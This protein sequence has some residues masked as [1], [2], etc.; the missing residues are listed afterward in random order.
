MFDIVVVVYEVSLTKASTLTSLQKV[1]AR[2]ACPELRK[3]YV[4]DNSS[5]RQ[6]AE[7]LDERF[8][9]HFAGENLGLAR[10]YNY[11]WPKSMAAGC[12]WLIT[13]DQD[14][15]ITGEYLNILVRNM[16]N[17]IEKLGIIA[18][19]IYDKGQQISPVYSNTLRPLKKALP[20]SGEYDRDIMVINS[21]A[22]VRITALKQIDGYN[23]FFSLDYLDHWL[24]WELLNHNYHIRVVATKLEHDLSVL[25]Y[26]KMD[27]D[28]YKQILEAEYC[29]YYD[30][31]KKLLP[32]L[33]KQLFLRASKQC[34]EGKYKFSIITF[35]QLRKSFIG[36]KK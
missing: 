9:Y 16:V 31:Q 7:F 8:V 10:A 2:F 36:E 26:S 12:E 28:R 3:I 6:A 21:G 33:K 34:V 4:I 35:N 30:Y 22:A 24:C 25:D 20:K 29:Y 17:N 15:T 5:K 1:L 18:P 19:E 11:V 32:S 14:T 13:L 23:E 27:I